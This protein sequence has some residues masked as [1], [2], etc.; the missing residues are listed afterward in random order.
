[1]AN[2]N[3]TLNRVKACADNKSV[4]AASRIGAGTGVAMI[5]LHFVAIPD[6]LREAATGLIILVVNEL[7]YAV[8]L[9]WKHFVKKLEDWADE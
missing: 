8:G 4:R 6:G 5:V 3:D 9:I 2:S 7:A 1:M